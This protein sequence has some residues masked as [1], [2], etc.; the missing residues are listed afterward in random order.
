MRYGNGKHPDF[1]SRGENLRHYPVGGRATVLADQPE[2]APPLQA[3]VQPRTVRMHTA[4]LVKLGLL[5]Q[6]EL[7]PEYRYRL[8][9]KA[10]QHNPEYLAR[11]AEAAKLHGVDL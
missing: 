7:F 9:D 2:I 5:E 10:Q 11:L 8:S 6:A 4:R 3:A 1:G